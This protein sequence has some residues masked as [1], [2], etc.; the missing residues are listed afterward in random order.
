M[1]LRAE[2]TH[3]RIEML[4]LPA[5]GADLFLEGEYYARDSCPALLQGRESILL[6]FSF[7]LRSF[8]ASACNRR[9]RQSI[10]GWGNR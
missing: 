1:R 7:M 10:G 5:L 8:R 6:P 9:A 4:H 2:Q 3:G